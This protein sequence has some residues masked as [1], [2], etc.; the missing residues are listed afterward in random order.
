MKSYF[1]T[2]YNIISMIY[3]ILLLSL[4]C[5]GYAQNLIILNQSNP[6]SHNTSIV[7]DEITNIIFVDMGVIYHILNV[8]VQS[9]SSQVNFELKR[10]NKDKNVE[11]SCDDYRIIQEFY[12]NMNYKRIYIYLGLIR[13][14]YSLTIKCNDVYAYACDVYYKL[15]SE[16]YVPS[17]MTG[18]IM[19]LALGVLVCFGSLQI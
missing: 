12:T 7:S 11:S 6:N 9:N 10:I 18:L 13:G 8:E 17:G 4:I 19:L 2:Y 14:N 1:G 15:S 3:T 5:I 16:I